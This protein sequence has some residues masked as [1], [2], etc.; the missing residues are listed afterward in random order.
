MI[1]W[2]F[3]S[4]LISLLA[5]LLGFSDIATR[6]AA[7]ARILFFTLL[8]VFVVSTIYGLSHTA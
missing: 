2:G 7:L 4:L 6:T 1:T 3:I 8:A 5:A